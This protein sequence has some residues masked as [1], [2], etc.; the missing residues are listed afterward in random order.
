MNDMFPTGGQAP[1]LENL[2]TVTLLEEIQDR[3]LAL[4]PA[5]AAQQWLQAQALQLTGSMMAAR[6]LLGQESKSITPLPLLVLVMFWFVIIF[7]SFGL[8]A[9]SNT[10][11]I[12]MIF[13]SS[14][15][16][17]GAIRMTTELQTPFTGFIR[18]SSGP[19]AHAL[20][21]ISR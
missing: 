6:W 17:G 21:I 12:A 8:F 15:A 10:T 9:P 19:L 1:D 5:G 2:S 20:D 3:I 16:I 18:I 11:A 7:A 4:R 14:V 13:L